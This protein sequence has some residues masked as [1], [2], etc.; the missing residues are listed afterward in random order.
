MDHRVGFG[1]DPIGQ[2]NRRQQRH[3]REE[4]V[5][6]DPGCNQTNVVVPSLSPAFETNK[7]PL[8]KR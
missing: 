7:P 6:G 1:K 5:E 4:P 2:N 3:Q 8:G